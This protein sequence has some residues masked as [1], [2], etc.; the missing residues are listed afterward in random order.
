MEAK[1]F[2][3]KSILEYRRLSKNP[4]NKDHEVFCNSCLNDFLMLQDL[5]IGSVEGS[6]LMWDHVRILME[7]NVKFKTHEQDSNTIFVI[8][9]YINGLMK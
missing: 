4:R 2:I 1:Y 7:H 8:A 9:T 6:Y 5:V 3:E